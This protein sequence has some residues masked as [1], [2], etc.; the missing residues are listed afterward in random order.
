MQLKIYRFTL[1]LRVNDARARNPVLNDVMGI[2][3]LRGMT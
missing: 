2:T 1:T 3:V